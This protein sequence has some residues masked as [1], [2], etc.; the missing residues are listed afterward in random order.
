M[1]KTA[2]EYKIERDSLR[3]KAT[4]Q[5]RAAADPTKSVWV[6]ASAGTG[7]TRVLSDRVLR[8][9]L[10]N[11]DA[12][13]I[14][15]LTY[16]KAAAVEMK[17]RIS[18]RLAEWAVMSDADLEKSLVN[19]LGSEIKNEKIM[20]YTKQIART[21]F[22]KL[23]DTPGGIKIQ[24]IH[25]FC[26]EILKRFPL[27]ADIMPYFDIMEDREVDD[28]LRHLQNRMQIDAELQPDSP[29][30]LALQYLN[31][32]LDERQFPQL[33][34]T[35]ADKRTDIASV[36]I[37]YHDMKE[38]AEALR[39]KLG[40]KSVTS[41]S[42]FKKECMH[43]ADVGMIEDFIEAWSQGVK[44]TDNDRAVALRHVLNSGLSD[45]SYSAYRDIFLTSS[46]DGEIKVRSK[47]I[48]ADVAKKHPQMEELLQKEGER[49]LA[50]E[51]KIRQMDLYFATLNVMIVA[52][53][54]I[55]RYD[56][57][58][59][60]TGK[61]DY[62]DLI[63]RTGELL[64][65][66]NMAD[67]VLYKLDG[68]I[69]HILIDEAQDTSPSQWQIIQALCAEFWAGEGLKPEATIFAVGDRK[70]SIFSFQGADPTKYD[71]M[72][73]ASSDGSNNFEKIDLE[74]SFRSAPAVLETVNRLFASPE[75]SHGVISSGE[76]V[77]HIASRAGEFGDV[78]IWPFIAKPKED[79]KAKT[80]ELPL[81]MPSGEISLKKQMAEKIV[82]EIERLMAESQHNGKPLKY[83]DF[84]VLVQRRSSIV[85]E[86]IRACKTHDI[87]IA[88][89]DK[90]VLSKEISVQD[91]LSLGKFLLLPEDDLSLAEVL[92]SPLF[93]LNDDD[94]TTLCYGRG[95][96]SLWQRLKQNENYQSVTE[97]LVELLNSLDLIRP[98]EL[99]NKVLTQMD[100]RYKMT[101]RMGMEVEDALDEFMNLTL[102]FEKENIPTLQG[103]IRWMEQSDA[104]VKRETDRK[105]ID[106]VRLMT[107]HR[108]KGL[109]API[110]FLPD[111]GMLKTLK[112]QQNLLIDDNIAYY[113]LDKSDYEEH[114]EAILNRQ[115]A[116]ALAENK[117]LLYVAL[118]RAEDRLY[119]CG[120][121]SG[122]SNSAPEN[123]WF[124]M[125]RKYLPDDNGQI[126][127][128]NEKWEHSSPDVLP[129]LQKEAE[130]VSLSRVIS[131]EWIK[132]PVENAV[133]L[134]KPWTPSKPDEYEDEPDSS[135]PLAD[136]G[137]YY[138]RGTIIHKLLQFLPKNKGDKVE[139]MREFLRINAADMSIKQHQ[140]IIEEVSKLLND[141]KYSVI[142]GDKAYSEVPIMGEVDGKIISAQL[143]KMVVTDDKIIIVDFKTNRPAAPSLAETPIAYKKQLAAYAELVRRIYHRQEVETY[144]LWT[145]VP[146]LM[147][148]F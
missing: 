57:Y 45:A 120:F 61:M 79:K 117:R 6:G 16:T 11:I 118:T 103:F 32:R 86:F 51:Q 133:P 35:V 134:A 13:K 76:V 105:D 148:V 58:K 75:M 59:Y 123:S 144:I 143:D 97:Q 33:M 67:W 107:V 129:K 130:G 131:P 17:T 122:N 139:V 39:Q 68:G 40:I 5:Q 55:N 81:L 62:N 147:R 106:A 141:E 50:Y 78:Q 44:K 87:P 102:S 99:Y 3:Q 46:K 1:V 48:C 80:A 71:A 132:E 84:M 26:Q 90:M 24:T 93:E 96:C 140:Q 85:T 49:I 137:Q 34:K 43:K 72:S 135:S 63:I 54:F 88:G 21:C 114:C 12:G 77:N 41:V 20:E 112:R 31:A 25:S 128:P 28:V 82:A 94:L 60:R 145:N 125:C 95:S 126:V 9:L 14:L 115:K 83:S 101:R 47:M 98:F 42:E 121:Q 142:F 104:E 111:A 73:K 146:R 36:L 7:K 109:Q 74:V 66:S 19:L 127:P 22:A 29:V 89:A 52:N 4:S 119:V 70:Q 108:S 100:G 124:D 23:L 30:S 138:R 92:K 37:K 65:K 15:C 69:D 53:D 2:Q 116:Q 136:T 10:K 113:P 91:L 56:E 18:E 110:V 8:M 64:C 38:F 27:E